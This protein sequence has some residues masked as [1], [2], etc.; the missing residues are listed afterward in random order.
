MRH[1][2]RK[3]NR[4]QCVRADLKLFALRS[5]DAMGCQAH[6]DTPSEKSD[7]LKMRIASHS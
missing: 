3:A 1:A 2:R 7:V 5:E 6:P 4:I